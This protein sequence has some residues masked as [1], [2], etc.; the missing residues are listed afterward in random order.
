MYNKDGTALSVENRDL[1]WHMSKSAKSFLVLRKIRRL[2]TKIKRMI[3]YSSIQN[4]HP[5]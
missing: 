2:G 4:I 1:L 3:Y 5:Y